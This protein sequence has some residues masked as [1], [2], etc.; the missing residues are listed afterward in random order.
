MS[1]NPRND[2]AVLYAQGEITLEE[3]YRRDQ[4]RIKEIHAAARGKDSFMQPWEIKARDGGPYE[5]STDGRL[6]NNPNPVEKRYN[7]D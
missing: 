4:I 7:N 3:Y 6:L 2:A 1:Y 5:T